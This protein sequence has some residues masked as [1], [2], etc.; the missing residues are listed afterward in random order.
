MKMGGWEMKKYL[1]KQ[2]MLFICAVIFIIL[3]CST[4][5][6]LAFVLQR[7]IDIAYK[8]TLTQLIKILIFCAGFAAFEALTCFIRDL[9]KTNYIKKTLITL[10]NDIFNKII[11]K[12]IENFN[13]ENSAQYIS[14]LSNDIN[15]V[16]QDYFGSIFN[17]IENSFNFIFGTI[18]LIAI[19][20]Y[21]AIAIFTLG[22]IMMLIPVIF[23][24]RLSLYK[25]NYSDSLSAYTVKIK[26]IFSGFEVIKS[27]N[28]ENKTKQEYSKSN[29]NVENTKRKSNILDSEVNNLSGV[30]SN[31]MFFGSLLIGSYFVI[32]GILTI[33][34]MMASVQLINYIFYPMSVISTYI[35]KIKSV[36]T[37]DEK[38]SKILNE[39]NVQ[40]DGMEKASIEKGITY[41]NV[42]FSYDNMNNILKGFSAEIKSGKKYVIVGASGCGKSTI[43]RLLMRYYDNYSGNIRIDG[44]DNRDIK[45]SSL[46]NI[47][48]IIHQNVFMFDSSIKDN[49]T[50]FGSYSDDELNRAVK[51][52][53]LEEVIENHNSNINS[54][55]GENGCYLS[56]GEKQRV[57]IARA[58]IKNTPVLILDE[59]TSSL[60]NKTSYSIENSILALDYLTCIV[61]THKLISGLLKKYDAIIAI[62][63]GVVEEIGTFDELMDNKGYFYSLYNVAQ[64]TNLH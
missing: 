12:N 29:Y 17:I 15:I 18:A 11:N 31:L 1:F 3:K 6:I 34:Y 53:G 64:E 57:A 26:D 8:G 22:S 13:E 58:I 54:K 49:I 37:I 45:A 38:L 47:I 63:N 59:A 40:E 51:L 5:I 42:V 2:K 33:G 50:L 43:I 20:I 32:K 39:Q 9:F 16:E 24:K 44:I 36:K 48:S 56:G 46:Y 60:D 25:K 7:V 10:K 55:V 21:I 23:R 14:I 4:N 52:S 62:K 30:L 35:G 19:N 61:V 27:F 28:I 41:E